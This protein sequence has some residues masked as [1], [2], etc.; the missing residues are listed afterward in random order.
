MCLFWSQTVAHS[1]A[2]ADQ[3][4]KGILIYSAEKCWWQMFVVFRFT[5]GATFVR[6]KCGVIRDDNCLLPSEL[7]KTECQSQ[8]FRPLRNPLKIKIFMSSVSE[9]LKEN[10]ILIIFFC[11]MSFPIQL[12]N[13]KNLDDNVID[14]KADETIIFLSYGYFKRQHNR[15]FRGCQ[16]LLIY[17]KCSHLEKP[18]QPLKHL[19]NMR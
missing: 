3:F 12:A 8:L 4:L 13:D 2:V 10:H 16:Q 15:L 11:L 7:S 14:R 5:C 6:C 17:Q 1:G 9:M 18:R 19:K